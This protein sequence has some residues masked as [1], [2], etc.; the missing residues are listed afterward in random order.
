MSE[1]FLCV[2]EMNVDGCGGF[3][4]VF[5]RLDRPLTESQLSSFKTE[6]ELVKAEAEEKLY[7]T[8][9]MVITAYEN[10]F[11]KEPHVIYMD[12]LEF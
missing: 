2:R 12:E 11:G 3:A 8:E 6:L 10:V 9:A 1:Q 4:Q 5:L 7:D